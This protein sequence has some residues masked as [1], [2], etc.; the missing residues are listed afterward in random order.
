MDES[1]SAL[2]TFPQSF[3]VKVLSALERFHISEVWVGKGMVCSVLYPPLTLKGGITPNGFLSA[4]ALF[5]FLPS[6]S[7]LP[8]TF[9]DLGTSAKFQL[10]LPTP[11][12]SY[13]HKGWLEIP[14]W[15][16]FFGILMAH[17]STDNCSVSRFPLQFWTSS[18]SHCTEDE[19][20]SLFFYKM[21]LTPYFP[22]LCSFGFVVFWFCSLSSL[23][24]SRIQLIVENWRFCFCPHQFL[25][26]C[27]H[28]LARTSIHCSIKVTSI[29]VVFIKV[30]IYCFTNKY[31]ISQF[32]G[33]TFAKLKKLLSIP[34][35]VF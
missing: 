19:S 30:C 27:F 12:L 29:L 4:V 15:W 17:W 1:V 3:V 10:S 18:S 16:R 31:D 8:C 22:V 25:A 20:N 2:L 26:A 7:N 35:L 11:H 14:L 5:T 28:T 23:T 24:R 32:G 34:N 9:E 13:N 21:F 33:H 6:D